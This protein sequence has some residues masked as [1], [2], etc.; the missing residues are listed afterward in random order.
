M[1]RNT[2]HP[3]P[4]HLVPSHLNPGITSA[5]LATM[6]NLEA[7]FVCIIL[8]RRPSIENPVPACTSIVH[9]PVPLGTRISTKHWVHVAKISRSPPC[10]ASNLIN[11]KSLFRQPSGLNSG[12]PQTQ[13]R[14]WVAAVDA[15]SARCRP[16]PTPLRTGRYKYSGLT[17]NCAARR[18][19]VPLSQF[20][21]ST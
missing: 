10:S 13:E 11:I 17:C 14:R 2:V 9:V 15:G 8:Y 5:R 21:L 7:A 18:V 1:L 16:P 6:P 20:Q 19:L 4:S 3:I 12:P